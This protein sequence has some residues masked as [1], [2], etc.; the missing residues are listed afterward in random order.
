MIYKSINFFFCLT[1]IAGEEIIGMIGVKNVGE[2]VHVI[3]DIVMTVKD[4][5]FQEVEVEIRVYLFL[6]K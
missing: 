1:G 3:E 4:V 5:K 6:I 2:V